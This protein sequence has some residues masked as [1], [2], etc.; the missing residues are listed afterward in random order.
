MYM[1]A[2]PAIYVCVC[3]MCMK[4]SQKPEREL[5]PLRLQTVMSH[6]CGGMLRTEL[7][8]SGIET[9]GLHH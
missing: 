7:R 5:D 4:Y 3:T 9:S 8:S 1:G 6:L 2:F